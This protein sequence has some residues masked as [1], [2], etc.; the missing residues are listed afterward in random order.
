MESGDC[1]C[2]FLELFF[3]VIRYNS[4]FDSDIPQANVLNALSMLVR[5]YAVARQWDAGID[6]HLVIHTLVGQL[7][8]LATLAQQTENDHAVVVHAALCFHEMV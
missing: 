4:I 7:T 6:K 8:Q 1:M 5:R 2:E 3:C